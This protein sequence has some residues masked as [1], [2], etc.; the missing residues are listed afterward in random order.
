MSA[1]YRSIATGLA[2]ALRVWL[3]YRAERGKEDPAR[4]AERFGVASEQRPPGR[5]VWIHGASVGEARSALPLLR[6]ILERYPLAQAL[7]TTGTLTSAEMLR[8]ALPE[9]ARHQFVPLDVPGWIEHF[10]DHWR[11]DAALWL[12]S[13]LW[14]TMLQA[15][16]RRGIPSALVNARLS[17]RSFASWRR[18]A[19]LMRSPV[20][21][22]TLVLA[23]SDADGGRLAALGARNLHSLGNLKFDAP[24]LHADI[25]ALAELGA[26]IG[27]RPVWLAAST[28]PGEEEIAADVHA[29]LVQTLPTLLTIVVPRHAVR[30]A[31]IAA[32]LRSR[33]LALAQRSAG[34]AIVADTAIYLADT[35]GELGLFYRL[36]PIAFIGKSLAGEGGQNPL[37]AAALDTAIVTGPRTGNFAEI[38]AALDGA[39]ALRVVR[40]AAD[41]SATLRMLFA[42]PMLRQRMAQG[43]ADV[44]ASGRGALTRVMTVLSPVLATLEAGP[45]H[46]RT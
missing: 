32:A 20:D 4:L 40:D 30:G 15:L 39:G 11:P 33:G 22:F 26:A 29:R 34:E 17:A 19:P 13:E 42:D 25:A 31:E 9:G 28:H 24:Q 2:P 18:V 23:Q 14:P 16:A 12:E 27:D 3:R 45:A 43:A 41:L 38:F 8:G 10:L 5:L 44:A 7:V 21:A 37:E 35:M 36:A 1:L 6:A 46:A